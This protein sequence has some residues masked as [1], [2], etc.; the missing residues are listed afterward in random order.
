[1]TIGEAI[2]KAV[3]QQKGITRESWMPRPMF[4]IP[5]NT[6]AAV[7]IVSSRDEDRPGKRWEPFSDDLIAN[8]WIVYG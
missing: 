2:N 7:L 3:E 1:M 8:D 4:L 5:T 6:T